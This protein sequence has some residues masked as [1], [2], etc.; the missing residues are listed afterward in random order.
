[1]HEFQQVC[2]FRGA[3]LSQRSQTYFHCPD[4]C[5]C[6]YCQ[7][8]DLSRPTAQL[9]SESVHPASTKRLRFWS[10]AKISNE[11]VARLDLQI[12]ATH[13]LRSTGREAYRVVPSRQPEYNQSL[14]E[15][16]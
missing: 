12:G 15:L 7:R 2:L 3:F 8:G 16:A 10:R 9:G 14:P 4:A 6:L 11:V 13:P 5:R 1:M